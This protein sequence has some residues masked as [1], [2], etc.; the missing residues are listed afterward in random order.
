MAIQEI[1]QINILPLSIVIY[2]FIVILTNKHNEKGIFKKFLLMLIGIV[3][4][5][6]IDNI[7]LYFYYNAIGGFAHKLVAIIGYN[8][9]INILLAMVFTIIRHNE[10]KYKNFMI[11]P[12]FACSVITFIGLFTNLVCSFDK[13]T[14]YMIRGPFSFTP[15]IVLLTYS[16][17]LVYFGIKKIKEYNKYEGLTILVGCVLNCI[18]AIVESQVLIR[19]PLIGSISLAIIFYYL[20][21]QIEYYKIDSLTGCWNRLTFDND[22]KDFKKIIDYVILIDL[23]NL[24]QINDSDGHIEGDKA[25]RLLAYNVKRCLPNKSKLYRVGGDEFVVTGEELKEWEVKK[26]QQKIINSSKNTKYNWAVG[27]AMID[28]KLDVNKAL[29][30]ADK[31]MYKIK[32]EIKAGIKAVASN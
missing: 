31:D 16:A 14:G 24:K 3:L 26:L 15:H 32:S 28:E 1:F 2:M 4:L 8:V 19:G 23:N 21:M 12:A 7:D 22:I 30:K 17:F 25:L 5:I 18:A 9:R 27:Y 11:L 29:N 13:T 6:I 10:S 20:A